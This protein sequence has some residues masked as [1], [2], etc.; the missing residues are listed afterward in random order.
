MRIFLFSLATLLSAFLLFWVQPLFAK[1]ILPQLGGSSSVWT[2]VML[3]FQAALVCGYGYVH[4]S[5]RWLPRQRQVALH[6]VFLLA[7]AIVLPFA[8]EGR[9]GAASGSPV[10]YV[11][12]LAT[13]SVGLPFVALSATAPLLQRWYT[14]T[15]RDPY[16]LYAASNLGSMAALLLFP[17]LLEPAL[18]VRPQTVVWQ[19]G[20]VLL[21]ILLG[22]CGLVFLRSSAAEAVPQPLADKSPL[23][24]GPF[25]PRVPCSG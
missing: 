25:C 10:A 19:A 23:A 6:T 4:L 17:T 8:V 12:I 18:A 3:F 5:D 7:A 15:G 14:A 24:A 11:L 13:F 1:M 9:E 16:F 20:Y 2:T 21:V 22:L